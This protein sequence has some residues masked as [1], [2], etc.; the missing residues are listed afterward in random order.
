MK[1]NQEAKDKTIHLQL[2]GLAVGNG[3]TN[4][5]IQYQYYAEMGYNNSHHIKVFDVNTYN[6]MTQ[7][8]PACTSMIHKC[9]S[10]DSIVSNFACQSAFLYCNTAETSP[11]RMTGLNPY[12]IRKQCG[13]NPLCYDFSHIQKFLNKKETK[14]A[15]NVD[16]QH[17]H[18][19]EACN[20]GINMKFHVDWMKDF[21]PFVA[22]LL[23]NGIPA[24][25]YAG[26]VDFICNYMGN[27]AWTY[28]L[29]WSGTE[30]FQTTDYHDWKGKGL[31]RTADGLTFLQIFD[32]G[33]MVPSDQP[34]V[35]L[36]M[37][38]TFVTGGGF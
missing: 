31:A 19:W 1:G 5:E 30:A 11:Y 8:I 37:I 23:N 35:A 13:D 17:S 27:K 10:G 9:N 33:H 24:L 4:P 6:A 32:A 36:D 3:L 29:D 20:F 26:D 14:M 7:A 21:S 25:I 38:R 16:P 18:A 12:D 28:N 34:E 22:D 2:A 15:L